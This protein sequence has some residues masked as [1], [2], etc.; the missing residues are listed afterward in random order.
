M[1]QKASIGDERAGSHHDLSTLVAAMPA[2]GRQRKISVGAL[3]VLFVIVASTIQLAHVQLPHITSFVPIVE[4]SICLASLLTAVFL[5]AQYSVY[6]LGAVLV[7]AG[8]FVF[9]GLF[10]FLHILAFPGTY[11]SDSLIGDGA[12]SLSW[13]FNFW[14]TL[15]LA[16]IVAHA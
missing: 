1:L 4:T 5:F 13:L 7:L 9:N 3:I 14:K 12:N 10:A 8:G 16:H 15:F 11:G 2:S 6:P